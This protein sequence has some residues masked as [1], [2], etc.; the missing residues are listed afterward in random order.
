MGWNISNIGIVTKYHHPYNIIIRLFQPL[1][2]IKISINLTI[3]VIIIMIIILITTV[4][5]ITTAP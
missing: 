4:K 5:I 3:I 1:L 2:I